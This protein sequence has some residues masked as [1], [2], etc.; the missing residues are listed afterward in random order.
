MFEIYLLTTQAVA[1]A[2]ALIYAANHRTN[3]YVVRAL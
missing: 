3:Q 2:R 1:E